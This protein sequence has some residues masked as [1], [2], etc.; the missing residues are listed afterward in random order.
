MTGN[1][2]YYYFIGIGGIGMSA[3][4]RY[5]NG[6]GC[7]VAGYDRTES[8]LTGEL[9]SE[10]IAIHFRDDIHSIPDEIMKAENQ[11]DTLVV[12]TPAVPDEHR[13]LNYFR[14]HDYQVVKRSEVLAEIFNRKTGIAVAGTHGKT[15]VSTMTAH[16]L[17]QSVLKCTA[18]L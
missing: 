8:L 9:Q 12:F 10:G 15:T 7:M 13:E 5:F 4:A 18:F 6:R 3:L 11:S 14:D 2:K 16:I 1:K 17:N